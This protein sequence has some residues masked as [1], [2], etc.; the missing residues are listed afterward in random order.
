MPEVFDKLKRGRDVQ[1]THGLPRQFTHNDARDEFKDIFENLPFGPNTEEF[2]T[3]IKFGG[4]QELYNE[5]Y[6]PDGL[7]PFVGGNTGTQMGGW[8]S[9]E[10]NQKSDFIGLRI[11]LAGFASEV[12]NDPEFGATAF[13][14]PV[15]AVIG[16]INSGQLDAA[17]LC[18]PVI[19]TNFGVAAAA[20]DRGWIYHFPG[21]HEP[22]ANAQFVFNKKVFNKLTAK[23]QEIVRRTMEEAAHETD[24]IINNKNRI[25]LQ[26]LINAGVRIHEF[27]DDLLDDLR[28]ATE[29]VVYTRLRSIPD[30]NNLSG[31]VIDSM[32][33]FTDEMS[34]YGRISEGAYYRTRD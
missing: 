21:W 25:A 32:L 7:L 17:E 5:F 23:E 14:S 31:R 24:L 16:L 30:F 22:T 12:L 15:G 34:E 33:L 20:I 9:R 18:C 13:P 2:Q 26:G 6:A 27:P 1:I 4:G 8:F 10:M 19:D 3:W 28:D 29:R 11:R